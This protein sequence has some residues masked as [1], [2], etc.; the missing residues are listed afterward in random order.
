MYARMQ[1]CMY[2]CMYQIKNQIF[3]YCNQINSNINIYNRG[4]TL[5]GK[6]KPRRERKNLGEYI[7]PHKKQYQDSQHDTKIKQYKGKPQWSILTGIVTQVYNYVCMYV[8]Y[9]YVIYIY[10]YFYIILGWSLF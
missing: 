3:F 7:G 2:T 10:I 8:I 1:T 6:V 9:I 5:E 4:T